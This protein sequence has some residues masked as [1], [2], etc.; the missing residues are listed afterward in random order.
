MTDRQ[1]EM[2]KNY[3]SGRSQ[4]SPEVKAA[5]NQKILIAAQK[6]E[7]KWIWVITLYAVIFSAAL[8]FAVWVVTGSEVFVFIFSIFIFVSAVSSVIITIV[9]QKE[10]SKGGRG[11]V[12][13]CN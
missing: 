7:S 2:L 1:D 5:L 8:A 3:F 13:I 4:P 6:R 11:N 9:C 10:R 12:A